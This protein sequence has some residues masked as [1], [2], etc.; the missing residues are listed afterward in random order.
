MKCSTYSDMEISQDILGGTGA[1]K[2]RV[3]NLLNKSWG[4]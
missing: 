3:S 4:K 2:E 1:A